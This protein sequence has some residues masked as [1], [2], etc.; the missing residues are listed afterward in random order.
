MREPREWSQLSLG[1][2]VQLLLGWRNRR[3]RIAARPVSLSNEIAEVMV[4]EARRAL[5]EL[6]DSDRRSYSG[7]PGLEAGEYLTLP[8]GEGGDDAAAL[9]RAGAVVGED[10]ENASGLIQLVRGAF[11]NDEFLSRDE[12]TGGRW[13]FYVVAVELEGSDVPVGF[14]R[15]YNPQRGFKAGRLLT[16]FHQTLSRFDDPLFNFDFDFDLIVAPDE[17]AILSTTAFDRL[18]A[19]LDLAAAQVPDQVAQFN[20]ALGLPLAAGAAQFLSV[21]VQGRAALVR[22]FRRIAQAPYLG[23][24]TADAMRT[25]LVRHGLPEDRFGD[26]QGVELETVE[27]VVVLLDMIEQLYYEADFTGEHRRAD[28]YSARQP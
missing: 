10:A 19:D 12:M 8:L 2:G 21:T 27:D 4:A 28:R 13:L 9:T 20:A 22:R 6:S 18:F 23:D 15:Q 26:G 7:V 1:T 5:A 11:E 25:A 16:A 14:V 24:V 17:I 3:R